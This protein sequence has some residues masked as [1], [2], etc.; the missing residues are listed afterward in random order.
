MI[1][2]AENAMAEH[3]SAIACGDEHGQRTA[4]KSIFTAMASPRSKP[5]GGFGSR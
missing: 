5:E 3:F 1:E 2:A 4:R